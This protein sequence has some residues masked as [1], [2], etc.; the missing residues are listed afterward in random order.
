MVHIQIPPHVPILAITFNMAHSWV[1]GPLHMDTV[2]GQTPRYNHIHKFS[3]LF[4]RA[5]ASFGMC[6]W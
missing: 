5:R 4:P 2:D 1:G 6:G 3:S